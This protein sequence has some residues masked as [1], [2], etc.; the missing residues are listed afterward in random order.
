MKNNEIQDR[1]QSPSK[2]TVP[3]IALILLGGLTAAVAIAYIMNFFAAPIGI[4]M[5]L[6]IGITVAA[7]PIIVFKPET[8]LFLIGFFLPFERIPT[9]ELGGATVRINYLL[10]LLLLVVYI[11]TQLAQKKLKIPKD[12]I[13]FFI[14][15]FLLLTFFSLP[16]SVNMT[17]SIEV[18]SFLILMGIAYLTITLVAQEGKKAVLLAVRGL[19]WGAL[20][21]AV[22]GLYQFFGD[23]VG[24]PISATLLKFGY[25]KTTFGFARIQAFS[26]EPLYFSNYLFIPFFVGLNCETIPYAPSRP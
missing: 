18:F 4:G 7:V 13:R 21:A 10:I 22:F 23:M 20:V 6:A 19:L 2:G 15:L 12:P 1:G 14:L 16:R 3:R 26:Q 5:A 8:G 25:D 11:L 9:I 17:R 24:L